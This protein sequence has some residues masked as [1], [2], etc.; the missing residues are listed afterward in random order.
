[1]PLLDYVKYYSIAVLKIDYL[2]YS[3]YDWW[4]IYVIRQYDKFQKEK[5]DWERARMIAFY[6]VAPHSKKIKKAT[7]LFKFS[8]EG[9]N[10]KG[11][12]ADKWTKEELE[13]IKKEGHP[14]FK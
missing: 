14:I 5:T 12:N 11:S 13:K 6:A 10:L 8:W 2:E 3:L 4:N 9:K 7:D 1:M